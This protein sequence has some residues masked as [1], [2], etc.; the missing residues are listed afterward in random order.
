MQ[1]FWLDVLKPLF[2]LDVF[3]EQSPICR[4]DMLAKAAIVRLVLCLACVFAS[5]SFTGAQELILE[6]GVVSVKK[7]LNIPALASGQL[8]KLNIKL[9][10]N[11]QAGDLLGQIDSSELEAEKT[12][13]QTEKKLALI[14]VENDINI[15]FS[16]R[17]SEVSNKSLLKACEAN[18]RYARTVSSLEVDRLQLE[19]KRAELSIERALLDQDTAKVEVELRDARIESLNTQIQSRRIVSP[20]SGIVVLSPFSAGEWVERGQTMARIIRTD[21]VDVV[22]LADAKKVDQHLVGTKV[23]IETSA[24]ADGKTK[25]V[26]GE[27]WYV[28]PEVNPASGRVQIRAQVENFDGLLRPGDRVKMFIPTK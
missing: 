5:A 20:G 9:G 3:P 11:V 27:I 28:T 8:V 4:N 17:S 6:N 1:A 13:L 23:F 25:K 12:V 2:K 16:R 18:K 10:Q 21:Q 22:A 15:R 19:A 26:A 7:E 14:V 24:K